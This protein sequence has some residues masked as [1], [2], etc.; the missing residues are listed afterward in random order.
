MYSFPEGIGLTVTPLGNSVLSSSGLTV[1]RTMQSPPDWRKNEVIRERERNTL[2]T[3]ITANGRND[4]VTISF[5]CRSLL[6]ISS[7]RS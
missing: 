6:S 1:G 7:Q 2:T 3:N 4:H 5:I